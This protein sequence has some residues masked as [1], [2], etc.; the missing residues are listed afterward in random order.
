MTGLSYNPYE[1]LAEVIQDLDGNAPPAAPPDLL[2]AVSS[3]FS[4]RK[5]ELRRKRRARKDAKKEAKYV[6]RREAR[7]KL[8]EEAKQKEREEYEEWDSDGY[9]DDFPSF[10]D[11]EPSKE[12]IQ[13]LIED[14][15]ATEAKTRGL[16]QAKGET[17]QEYKKRM[18][19]LEERIDELHNIKAE[20]MEEEEEP[21]QYIDG[22]P[23][24]FVYTHY[25]MY[26]RIRAVNAKDFRCLQ[27]T[28]KGGRCSRSSNNSP[29]CERCRRHG[30]SCLIKHT[31]KKDAQWE[32][33]GGQD[34][35]GR[36][37]VI[38]E[39]SERLENKD[40]V[41]GM[42]A[43]PDWSEVKDLDKKGGQKDAPQRWQDYLRGAPKMYRLENLVQSTG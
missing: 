15:I 36:E 17:E 31:E 41:E 4:Q 32:F 12:E 6:A 5:A 40:K 14:E 2:S 30:D 27:C 23:V 9:D 42:Q 26:P 43:L 16:G 34:M 22:F 20:L 24:N 18:Q 7:K 33:A 11:E 25:Y 35:E 19:A 8:E 38:K 29:I 1:L 28:A 13:A 10:E 37:A 3:L 21:P 39:W